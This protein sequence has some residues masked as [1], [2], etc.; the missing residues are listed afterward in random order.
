MRGGG[1]GGERGGTILT[2][3]LLATQFA[4]DPSVS[5]ACKIK[6]ARPYRSN[7]L[8]LR[9][10]VSCESQTSMMQHHNGRGKGDGKRGR[11]PS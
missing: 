8:A 6:I 1:G 10:Q 7:K 11:S 9:L 3:T 4:I 2:T 5:L